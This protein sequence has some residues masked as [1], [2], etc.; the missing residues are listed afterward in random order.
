M[1]LE[2]GVVAAAI[3][4]AIHQHD[5]QLR[6]LYTT[7]VQYSLPG[8]EVLR[9]ALDQMRSIGGGKDDHAV[10]TFNAAFKE[11]KEAIKRGGEL[12]KSLNETRLHDISRARRVLNIV[13]PFLRDEPDMSDGDREHAKGLE[14]LLARETFFRS[15]PEIDQHTRALEQEYRR[16]HGVAA[17]TRAKAYEGAASKLRAT[18]GWEHLEH[19]QQQ[20]V[21]TPLVARATTDGTDGLTIPLLRAELTA[22]PGLLDK[23]VEDMLRLVDGNRVVRVAV[24]SYFSGGIETEEQ[25]NQAISGLKNQCLELIGAGK[26]VLIQ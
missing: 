8:A 9:S 12:A 15:L 1:E 13:W 25:L 19:D 21:A 2:Q 26:K 16:L 18:P 24:S 3:R 6:E 5:E 7:L 22:C 23:A 10:L 4:E 11:I 17:N 14:D 20:R